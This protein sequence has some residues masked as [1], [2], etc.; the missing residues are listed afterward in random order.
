MM[1]GKPKGSIFY[2][3]S[4]VTKYY[5][6]NKGFKCLLLGKS[7]KTLFISNYNIMVRN[8]M[9]NERAFYNVT[10]ITQSTGP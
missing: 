3:F 8:L 6:K 4:V 10:T 5:E 7:F 2:F 9:L 1:Y